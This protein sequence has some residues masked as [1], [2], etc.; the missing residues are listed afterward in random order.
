MI[1][2]TNKGTL[3]KRSITTFG[4][5]SKENESAIGYFGTGLKYAIAILLREGCRIT[6]YTGGEKLEFTSRK[7]RIRVNDFEIVLMNN[8]PMAFTTEL[9]KKWSLWQ[10]FRELYCNAI[11]EGG[12]VSSSSKPCDANGDTVIVVQGEAF[13]AVYESRDDFILSSPKLLSLAHMDVHEGSSKS[14]FYRGIKV[15]ST[16]VRSLFTYNW[17]VAV[18]LTEDRSVKYIGFEINR[19]MR[20]YLICDD[21]DILA[22]ALHAPKDTFEGGID[23]AGIP[24]P[25]FLAVCEA[26]SSRFDTTLNQSAMALAKNW[27]TRSLEHHT[28]KPNPLETQMLL[29][30][31]DFCNFIGYDTSEY[32]VHCCKILGEN[33]L[34]IA[35]KGGIYL[36]ERVFLQ[37]TKQVA[38]TLLEE[39]F[40]LKYNL[41]DETYPMQT[42]LFDVIGQLGEKLKGE[43]L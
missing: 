40:H 30:A 20:S 42:F 15:H 14:L 5:S 19:I 33:V 16:D 3:D 12:Y 6:I 39:F 10:A 22:S 26:A 28:Y 27:L 38:V 21:Y 2:F 7:E 17:T 25:T 1:V 34:G 41:Q 13:D 35:Y 36:S 4:V 23:Y 29:K 24:G 43:P 31:R 9:G 37:G 8:A 11:D 18:D 32:Q